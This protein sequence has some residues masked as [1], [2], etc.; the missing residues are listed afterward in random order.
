ML[1]GG[2]G[3]QRDGSS[4]ELRVAAASG[5]PVPHQLGGV[6]MRNSM[7]SIQPGLNNGNTML[8]SATKRRLRAR[9]A[10]GTAQ[11]LNSAFDATEKKFMAAPLHK[12][13][14]VCPDK[15]QVKCTGT[16]IGQTR[17]KLARQARGST[18]DAT[19][20][21][22]SSSKRVLCVKES[23]LM[24]TAQQHISIMQMWIRAQTAVAIRRISQL[25]STCALTGVVY[26]LIGRLL[27]LL[28]FS[29]S[30]IVPTMKRYLSMLHKSLIQL[31]MRPGPPVG[32][33][34]Q[35]VAAAVTVQAIAYLPRLIV[36]DVVSPLECIS[37]GSDDEYDSTSVS[38]G[39]ED[40]VGLHDDESM[41]DVAISD[42]PSVS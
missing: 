24:Q 31:R 18:L 39:E 3:P 17:R 35:V 8:T 4:T 25:S 26:V 14:P 6:Q 7:H 33:I 41:R 28:Q 16:A 42:K 29:P 22:R 20:L 9:V 30:S 19:S 23:A 15:N 12:M 37:G 38:S 36:S 13:Q 5:T 2:T 32:T 1:Y 40:G 21:A 11:N 34:C 10:H 27:P